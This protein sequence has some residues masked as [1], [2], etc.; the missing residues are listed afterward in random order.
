MSL[1]ELP[2]E[3]RLGA[4]D[5]LSVVADMAPD[6]GPNEGLWPGLTTYRFTRPQAPQ[7]AEVNTLAL[8]CVLQG[9]KVVTVPEGRYHYDPFHYLLFTRGMRFEAEILDASP[10]LPFL[11][12]VL[13][14]DPGVVRRVSED[15]GKRSLTTFHRRAPVPEEPAAR[16]SMLDQNLRGALLRF[17]RSVGS[18][19]E[20]RV[21]APLYL[22]EIAYRLLQDEQ[23]ERV[24]AGA[25]REQDSNPVAEVLRYVNDHMCEPLTVRD[26]AEH[27][28]MSPSAF[29]HLF[30]E[31]TGTAPYQFVKS[32]R[33]N[34][35]SDLLVQDGL[36]VTE[37]MH[38]VGYTS[39]SHFTNEFKRHFGV[40]PRAY[41]LSR[42]GAVP[43]RISEAT[44]RAAVDH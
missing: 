39:L 2:P 14:L 27:V 9:R 24:L 38:Q 15:L 23:A 30:R 42:S 3:E 36:N 11:S 10:E 18:G 43:M 19:A 12:V 37:V 20:R 44:T 13:Q 41:A 17:L 8:C 28:C 22:Q 32:M 7:W 29:A 31:A 40:T 34:R 6:P 21:L 4:G 35:A 5:L 1:F 16:V 25:L 26:L 33:L